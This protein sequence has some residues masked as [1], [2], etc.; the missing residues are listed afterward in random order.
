MALE[1]IQCVF[2]QVQSKFW[3]GNFLIFRRAVALPLIELESR[4]TSEKIALG[5]LFL[6][7]PKL[8]EKKFWL[9]NY[10]PYRKVAFSLNL[11]SLSGE[12]YYFSSGRSAAP[13]WVGESPDIRKD[14]PRSP[15][16]RGTKIGRKQFLVKELQPVPQSRFF[17]RR[18]ISVA[19]GNKVE[20]SAE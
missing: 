12:F 1:W 6:V 20:M 8:N 3:A 4:Q 7:V 18:E 9:R 13:D 2:R 16:S 14:S 15:L 11:E 19:M 5:L 10:S 17:A